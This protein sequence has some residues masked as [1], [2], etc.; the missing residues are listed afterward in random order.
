V[1]ERA[2]LVDGEFKCAIQ[3]HIDSAFW[4]ALLNHHG[5]RELCALIYTV[6]DLI[7]LRLRYELAQLLRAQ[8]AMKF[9]EVRDSCGLKNNG[10][11]GHKKHLL[12]LWRT[13]YNRF[14]GKRVDVLT[15]SGGDCG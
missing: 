5:D 14:C 2:A 13:D 15:K 4:R 1:S 7:A 6:C 10:F 11:R 3:V 8:Q 9:G 12:A